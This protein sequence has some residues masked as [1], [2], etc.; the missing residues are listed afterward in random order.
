MVVH[1]CCSVDSWYFLQKIREKYP[2][3]ALIGFFYNPNIHPESE[4]QTR[5]I[6]SRR[7]CEQLGIAWMEGDYDPENWMAATRGLEEA[8]EKGARCA[9]CFDQRLLKTAE[10]ADRLGH[11]TYTTTLLMSP[12]KDFSQLQNAADRLSLHYQARFIIEDFRKKGG[13][14]AQFALAKQMAAYQQDYCGCL[15]ALRAQRAAQ[16]R[17]ALELVT[18]LQGPDRLA[19]RH[20]LYQKREALERAGQSPLLIRQRKMGWHLLKGGLWRLD[21]EAIKSEILA[22]SVGRYHLNTP[23]KRVDDEI[24]LLQKQPGVVLARSFADRHGPSS[25]SIRQALGL[26]PWDITPIF[27]VKSLPRGP[28]RVELEAVLDEESGGILA[29]F[30]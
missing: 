26:G 11:A 23:L 13:T 5:L 28:L 19:D 17:P 30:Q 21:G 22:Y 1:I 4:Y 24:A 8:P 29:H 7:S 15:Y 12:K 6:D 10:L 20:R 27:I 25:A 14:Q 2:D 9:V 16:N 3:E 18:P